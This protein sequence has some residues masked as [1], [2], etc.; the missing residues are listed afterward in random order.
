MA[1]STE[2]Q[3]VNRRGKGAR[4]K[5]A[6]AM[7]GMTH[8]G[9]DGTEQP[10]TPQSYL[11]ALIRESFKDTALAREVLTRLEPTPRA[12]LE[13]V[14]FD[15][16]KDADP[17]TQIRSLLAALAAGTLTPDAFSIAMNGIKTLSAVLETSEHERRLSELEQLIAAERT[18][19]QQQAQEL[20]ET[21]YQDGYEQGRAAALHEIATGQQQ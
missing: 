21:A 4:G 8:K 2:N 12:S 18:T 15:L 20:E 16:D 10:L 6:E 11:Q 17:E 9:L 1:F 19:D 3:P 14:E 7:A 13:A 5:I